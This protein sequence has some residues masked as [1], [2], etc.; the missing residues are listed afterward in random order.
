MSQEL[1]SAG[2]LLDRV[3][4]VL[5]CPNCEGS[6]LATFYQVRD[7]PVHSVLLMPTREKAVAY[8]RGD[9]L[10]GFCPSCGF[11]SN[12][13]F[14]VDR[15]D[16]STEYE[17]T[18]GFSPVFNAFADSLAKRMVEDYGVRGQTVL[19]IG[20]GKAEFLMRMVDFGENQGI[21]VDPSIVPERIPAEYTDRI[22]I[23]PELYSKEHGDF[24]ADFIVCRHTLEHIAPTAEFLRTLRGAI[25][26]R[27]DTTVFFE[28]PETLRVLEEGA[29]WDV[30]YEHCSYFTPG[31]LARLFR[32]GGFDI[33]ELSLDYDDQYIL[34]VAKPAAGPTEPAF[35]LEDDLDALRTLVARFETAA[36]ETIGRW[37]TKIV[38]ATDAGKKVAIWGAGSK[39]VAFLTTLGV[40]ERIEVLVDV[41]PYKQGRFMPGTGQEVSAPDFLAEYQPDL[42]IAMNP[43]YREEIQ[44]DLDRMGVQAELVAV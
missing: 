12:V 35:A 25:G 23:I 18:Q 13:L 14:D 8:P 5:P 43:I 9:L 32:A 30:Y 42:V 33:V 40:G 34:L 10:L 44:A 17:E 19:E 29:F 20:C 4:P 36:P 39:A 11:I 28:L 21:G 26:D 22:A 27:M 31:S 38:E 7:V 6:G 2:T 15:N 16:Y 24:A 1:Q 41:N 37:R 3:D